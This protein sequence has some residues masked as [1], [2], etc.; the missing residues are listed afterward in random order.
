MPYAIA[1][2]ITI[3]VTIFMIGTFVLL[4]PLSRRLG[5]VM[6]E[7]IQV[8][9]ESSPDRDLLER[10]VTEVRALRGDVESMDARLDLLGDRQ[11]FL[12]SLADARVRESLPGRPGGGAG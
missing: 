11:E 4:F 10:L 6:E 12:E 1:E 8:R 9:R 5:R 7:W 2:L 3:L